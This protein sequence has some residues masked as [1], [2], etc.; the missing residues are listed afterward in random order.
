MWQYSQS[1]G[2]IFRDG[3][4]IGL[5]YSGLGADK[6]Q[7]ADEDVVD[8]GPIP[9]GE[10]TTGPAQDDPKLGPCVMALTPNAGNEMFGRSGFFL[11][12]D[13]ASHP[14]KASHGCIVMDRNV[15]DV[16]SSWGDTAL[17]VVA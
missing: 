15:R 1:T 16:I 2:K 11:H 10:Y 8:Q 14:G 5:G 12:G 13:S 4:L 9:R 6:D 17:T 3:I 7:P